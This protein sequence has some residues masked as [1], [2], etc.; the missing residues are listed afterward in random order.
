MDWKPAIQKPDDAVSIP[1]RWV[2]LHYYEALNILFRTENALRVFVYVVLKN[3][4]HE[5]WTEAAI[6]VTEDEQSTI[7]GVAAKRI[8]Q[9]KGF[10]Y[11]GYEITSPLM[12]LNSGE[13]I[14][15]ITSDA[16][17]PLFSRYFKGRREVIKTK[18]DEV[19]TVRNSLA[20]FRPIKH[21]DVELIKQNVKHALV[22]IEEC[23][24]EMTQTYS[25]VP[26]NTEEDWYKGLITLGT[27]LCAVQ[28][29]QSKREE[30]LR[31]EVTYSTPILTQRQ[32]GEE[33]VSY[34]VLNLLSPAIVRQFPQ[35]SRLCTYVTEF[36]PYAP[37]SNDL[38]PRIT[39]AVSLV[40]R[41]ATAKEQYQTL[42]DQLRDVL[43]Q[44]QKESELVQ[45]DHLARGVLVES[46]NV[47]AELRTGEG[48]RTW[49]WVNTAPLAC[50]FSENDP[51]EYWGDIGLYHVDFVAGT[52][53][54]PWMP[55]DIS[56]K[57][58]PLGL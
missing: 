13:L 28:L 46:A 9:A 47:Y 1:K 17:W 41:A 21:D 31:V 29:Y 58:S 53:K 43:L 8:A 44:V 27:D 19:G 49:W 50:P 20:H 12:H 3:Q 23:L 15:L 2:H 16:Y 51:P 38:V 45:K 5:K 6:Q 54:Y 30:W 52:N 33:F 40:F 56:G 10:G 18:L 26:T 34:R 32:Y 35:V 7:A 36:V 42:C 39:K 48:G 11:L 55:S 25:V 4:N 37:V 14:R 22:G 24:S 57:E